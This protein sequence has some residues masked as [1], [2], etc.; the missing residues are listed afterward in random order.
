MTTLYPTEGMKTFPIS[1]WIA[2]ADQESESETTQSPA[3]ICCPSLQQ[4]V[5]EQ[6]INR[7]DPA[8][9]DSFTT[10]LSLQN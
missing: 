5:Q 8:A 9:V 10:K 1:D 7:E 3:A 6:Q 2:V 4:Y